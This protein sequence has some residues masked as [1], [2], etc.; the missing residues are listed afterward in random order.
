MCCNKVIIEVSSFHKC[1]RNYAEKFADQSETDFRP[2]TYLRGK[3]EGIM[4]IIL[5]KFDFPSLCLCTNKPS[6]LDF[7]GF[8]KTVV[9]P[10]RNFE[11]GVL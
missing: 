6:L 11:T 4:I 2:L 5:K 1:Q 3:Q 9:S 7:V 8:T 10:F